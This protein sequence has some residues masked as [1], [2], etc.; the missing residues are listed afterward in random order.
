MDNQHA[1][2]KKTVFN[3]QDTGKIQ[4]DSQNLDQEQLNARLIQVLAEGRDTSRSHSSGH[5][6][7]NPD[8][9]DSGDGANNDA[10]SPI[11]V[12]KRLDSPSDAFKDV[13]SEYGA[14]LSPAL[15]R[16]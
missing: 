16:L 9:A 6:L 2:G 10:Y 5:K 7:S 1:E 3:Y 13:F 12:T 4:N 11:R 8:C 14:K 15:R